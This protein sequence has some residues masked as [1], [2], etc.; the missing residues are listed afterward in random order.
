MLQE[1]SG[2]RIKVLVVWEPVLPTDWTA[3]S[4]SA[5]KRIADTRATQFWDKTRLVSQA[6]GE[7]DEDTV[8]WDHVAVY[9]PGATW[10]QAPPED[11]YAN[12]PVIEAI[13]RT[14]SAIEQGLAGRTP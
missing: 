13:A 10:N 12:T 2:K 1:F 9:P 14:R 3:P 11:L 4:T 7:R 8:V 5:L 6:M